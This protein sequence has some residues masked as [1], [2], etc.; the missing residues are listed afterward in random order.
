ML[1]DT[2]ISYTHAF[3]YHME[4]H[5]NKHSEIYNLRLSLYHY[6]S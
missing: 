3:V 2:I 4:A 6:G 5:T 1:Q